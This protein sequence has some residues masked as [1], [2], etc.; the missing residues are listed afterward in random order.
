MAQVVR[1]WFQEH[2]EDFFVLS[3]LFP[4]PNPIEHLWDMLDKKYLPHNLQHIKELL[5]TSYWHQIADET[6]RSFGV[7]TD[8]LRVVLQAPTGIITY[9]A[10]GYRVL[11][12]QC[13]CTH[14]HTIFTRIYLSIY[15]FL[16]KN[17]NNNWQKMPITSSDFYLFCFL[18]FIQ[19]I[20]CFKKYNLFDML[21]KLKKDQHERKRRKIFTNVNFTNT[22]WN[23]FTILSK[24][25]PFCICKIHISLMH[26]YFLLTLS[27]S[28]VL[29]HKVKQQ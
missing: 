22:K 16:F 6:F 15:I 5:L 20:G 23:H 25:S 21:C 26:I 13:K 18:F 19:S 1:E 10:G 8:W 14:T 9:L 11:A 17:T 29:F 24:M 4:D 27:I 3:W 28:H 7:L 12:D 2:D